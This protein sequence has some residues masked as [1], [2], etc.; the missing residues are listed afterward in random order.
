[1]FAARLPTLGPRIPRTGGPISSALGH[2]ALRLL[3]WR[4]D[5]QIPDVPKMVIIVAPHSSNWDFIIGIAA[6]LG[7][8]LH[9]RYLGKDTLFRFPLGIVMRRLGGIPVD[10]SASNDV[11]KSVAREFE[12]NEKMILAVAPEGTRKP[13]DR[14]RTGFYHIARA[15]DVPIL[16]VAINWR[17]RAIEIGE[18]FYPTGDFDADIAA[19]RARFASIARRDG[20]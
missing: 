14:W 1:V 6:K 3:G 2:I 16:P 20:T 8:R 15:A 11:V 17:S 19:L 4:V 12:M 13:V 9:V 10:R 5:G 18:V 7:M